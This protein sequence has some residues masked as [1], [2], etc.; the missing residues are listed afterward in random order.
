MKRTAGWLVVAAL[1]VLA[2]GLAGAGSAAAQQKK[3]VYWTHWDQTPK[4]NKWYET[5]GKEFAKK[6]GYEVEVV[7]IPAQG[8]EPKYLAGL[9]G[10]SGAPDFFFGSTEVWCGQHDFCDPMPPN[11]AKTLDENLLPY[12]VPFGKWKGV[13]YGTPI[14]AGNFMQM[15]INVE[16]FKKAG[17]DPDKPLKTLDEWLAAMKKLTIFDAKG[18]PVQVGYA[19]RHAGTARGLGDKFLPF[20]HAFGARMVS[21]GIDKAAGY[22]NSPE[23]VA[24]LQYYGDLVHKHKIATLAHGS[25]EDAFAQKRAAV[26]FRESWFYG[27]A[28]ANA[29]DV[30]VKVY[31]LPCGKVCPGATVFF[32]W[33]DL[34]YKHSPNKQMAWEFI[35]FI[36]N[37]K[38][39]LEHHQIDGILP[40]WKASYESSYVKTRPDYAST[41]EMMARPPAPVYVHPK[42]LDMG[43]AVGEAISGVL[44][45]KEDPKALLDRAAVKIQNLIEDYELMKK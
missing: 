41:Q 33:T 20:A 11:L 32:P 26:M 8:S 23:M 21:P 1:V 3:L 5:K 24:A 14:E 2:V 30:N 42:H 13:R 37:A 29:P 38:D 17:L 10:R 39:D 16:M 18:E 44:F 34:V 43:A 45:R 9:M 31:P 7:T 28:K 36:S 15:Y 6:T 27:W 12:L 25:P 22:V 40:V 4:F 19:I 35:R